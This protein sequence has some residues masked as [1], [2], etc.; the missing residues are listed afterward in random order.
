M[1]EASHTLIDFS[2]DEKIEY[3][4]VVASIAIADGDVSNEEISKLREICKQVKLSASGMGKVLSF[5]ENPSSDEVHDILTKLSDSQLK[6]TLITD[7]IFLAFADT[8]FSEHEKVEIK[9]VAKELRISQEQVDSIEAY[10]KAVLKAQQSGKATDDL[11]RLGGDVAAGL[12]SAGVPIGAVA[13]SGSV[14]GLSAAGITSG[15][16]ALGL[17]LGMT[18]GIGVVAAIGVGSYFGVRWLYKKVVGA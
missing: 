9:R 11:K 18:T 13:V 2:D 1:K 12:T 4:C 6:F 3:L 17:G 7:M 10:V 8:K 5:A 14:F 16:A 15:L